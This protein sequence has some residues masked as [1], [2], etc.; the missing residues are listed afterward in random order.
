MINEAIE[1]KIETPVSHTLIELFWLIAL[2]FPFRLIRLYINNII[3]LQIVARRLEYISRTQVMKQDCTF[4]VC[5][6]NY[7]TRSRRP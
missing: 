2:W 1:A 4:T 5:L 7:A 6:T 3:L